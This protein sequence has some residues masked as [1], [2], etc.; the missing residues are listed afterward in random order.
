MFGFPWWLSDKES[1]CNAGVAREAGSILGREDPLEEGTATHSSILAWRISWTEGPGGLRS[2]GS[3]GVRHDRSNLAHTHSEFLNLQVL[4]KV[5][6]KREPSRGVIR[7]L[8]EGHCFAAQTI[9]PQIFSSSPQ[10]S[11]LLD[12]SCCHLKL[13]ESYLYKTDILGKLNKCFQFSSV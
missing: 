4:Q 13:D 8:K 12:E 10:S 11:S 6:A 5:L 3:Q 9:S 2:T 1:A 7:P